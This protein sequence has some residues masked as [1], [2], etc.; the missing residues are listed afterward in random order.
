MAEKGYVT[1]R[2]IIN[3]VLAKREEGGMHSYM[4]LKSHALDFVKELY[5]DCAQE[6][7]T[8]KIPMSTLKTIE[9]PRDYIALVKIGVQVGDKVRVFLKDSQIA[10]Y[11]NENDCGTPQANASV[12]NI[13][14]ET[15]PAFYF[16]N[17]NYVNEFGEHKGGFYG[18]ANGQIKDGYKINGSTV[19]FNSDVDTSDVYLEYVSSG[20]NPSEETLVP[21]I[22]ER[23]CEDWINWKDKAYKNG[24]A[25]SDAYGWQKMYGKDF[26]KG[27]ARAFPLNV[28][29]LLH[30]SRTGYTLSPRS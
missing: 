24:P 29:E 21:A 16:T 26:N 5:Q 17:Y 6:V 11:F 8:V 19:Y 13:D 28:E 30:A 7:K 2:S 3:S 12:E 1:L 27:K 10:L 14:V 4:R 23:A 20:F 25:S 22:F 15:N 9:L 18:Y